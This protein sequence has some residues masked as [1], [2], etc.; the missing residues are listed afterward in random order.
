V[1][2][3]ADGRIAINDTTVEPVMTLLLLLY[4]VPIQTPIVFLLAFTLTFD[5]W[6][7]RLNSPDSATGRKRKKGKRQHEEDD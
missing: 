4:R 7:G 3:L 5:A 6:V 2:L 1:L